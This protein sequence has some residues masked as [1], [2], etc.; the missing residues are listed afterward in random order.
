MAQRQKFIL[1]EHSKPSPSHIAALGNVPLHTGIGIDEKAEG[2]LSLVS[3][4]VAYSR[5]VLKSYIQVRRF[6]SSFYSI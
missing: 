3:F 2:F 5:L 1:K 6:P 4:T